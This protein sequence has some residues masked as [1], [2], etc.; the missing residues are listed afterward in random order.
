LTF[1][2]KGSKFEAKRA[3][4]AEKETKQ[5]KKKK[6]KKKK[7]IALQPGGRSGTRILGKKGQ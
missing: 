7:K 4:G 2:K 6:K 3:E 5:T 1:R